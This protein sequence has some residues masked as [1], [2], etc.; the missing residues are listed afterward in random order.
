MGDD[1]VSR[2]NPFMIR[3][4]IGGAVCMLLMVSFAFASGASDKDRPAWWGRA[5]AS[6]LRDGY[7]LVD[8]EALR[9]IYASGK[10]FLILDVRPDYE[11][12]KGHLP[13]AVQMEFGLGEKSRITKEKRIRFQNLLGPDKKRAIVIYCRNYQ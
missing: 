1:R 8:I 5:Q 12:Q 6:A 7:Q 10:G 2:F 13:G 9:A 3:A 4:V 11:Y